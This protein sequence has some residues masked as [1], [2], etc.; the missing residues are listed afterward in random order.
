[1]PLLVSGGFE[2]RMRLREGFRSY[3]MIS[4]KIGIIEIK[5]EKREET[6]IIA[7]CRAAAKDRLNN[8]HKC[9]K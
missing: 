5:R 1:M 3:G 9:G 7:A 2:K 6:M 8:F 4:D